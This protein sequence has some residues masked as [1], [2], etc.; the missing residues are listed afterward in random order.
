MRLLESL[1]A[2]G[3]RRKSRAVNLSPEYLQQLGQRVVRGFEDAS[4][5]STRFRER[6]V[7][8][9][10]NWRGV[11]EPKKDFPFKGAANVRVAFTSSL[12]EQH[13]ARYHRAILGE[14]GATIA[15][16]TP[17]G[18]SMKD[19]DLD[20]L[21]KW[22]SWELQEVVGIREAFGALAHYFLLDGFALCAPYWSVETQTVTSTHTYELEDETPIMDQMTG[23]LAS[24][25]DGQQFEPIKAKT[26]TSFVVRYR[27]HD[28]EEWKEAPVDFYL[29]EEFLAADVTKEEVVFDGVKLDIP[30]TEDTVVLNVAAKPKDLPFLG[31]RS[32]ITLRTF[33]KNRAL[34]KY[35]PLAKE[36]VD[37][38]HASAQGKTP[39]IIPQDITEELDKVEGADSTDM[40]SGGFVTG[41]PDRR[42]IEQYRWEGLIEEGPKTIRAIVW[43]CAKTEKVFRV[44]R[45]ED[46]APGAES[47]VVKFEWLPVPKRWY[48]I[49]FVEW[50]QHV[51]AELDGIHNQRLDAGLISMVP[52]GFYEPTAGFSKEI[53]SLEIGKLYPVR[54]AQGVNFPRMN[55]SPQWSFQEEAGVWQ[56]GYQQAGLNEPSAGSF[57][58]KRQSA[59]EF[60]GTS[61]AVDLR[62][63]YIVEG[64]AR[65]FRDLLYRIFSLYKRNARPGR[66]FQV[67]TIDG[68]RR[69]R[70]LDPNL[71]KTKMQ[72]SLTADTQRLSQQLQRDISVNMLSLLMNPILFQLG[73]VKPD[74][75]Y[76]A[77]EKVAASMG[78]TGVPLY[79]PDVPPM[80]DPPHI[81]NQ[82]IA[83]GE[84]V[85]PSPMEAFGEHLSVHMSLL[86]DPRVADLLSPEAI[87]ALQAHVRATTQMQQQVMMIRA[88]QAGM[89]GD[90]Q[91]QMSSMGIRPGLAGQSQ[92]GAQAS[93][94][95]REEG[96]E[97]ERE[98]SDVQTRRP[99]RGGGV[100]ASG[101]EAPV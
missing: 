79:K 66:I 17:V 13:K 41:D 73:V 21:N 44:T 85:A 54:N 19:E 45:L 51:Q 39:Q 23:A 18:S 99:P 47:S 89:A 96:V 40:A 94:G 83:H 48:P 59:S 76:R 28:G 60:L 52:F 88:S 91:S 53:L 16:F 32:W 57:V 74:T 26:P 87:E 78:Y 46:V 71:L 36:D 90:M 15:L 12:T 30:D 55:W 92:P 80:S 37:S 64:I 9:T 35:I 84:A 98:P 82:K 31:H 50:V 68:E 3:L 20:D 97:P 10:K 70:S 75:V 65:S 2:K 34:G 38:I 56:Y 63:D 8:Y 6:H 33:E 49:G 86:S 5:T 11:P 42:Y 24:L 67:T 25:F 69:F 1:R 93:A 81:E 29:E 62:T 101:G 22:F 7:L 95:T 14:P 100:S 77:L 43:V 27:T 58:S 4:G 72:I 61:G